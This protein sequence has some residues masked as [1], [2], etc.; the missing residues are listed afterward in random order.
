MNDGHQDR[1]IVRHADLI[2]KL[3]LAGLI[4]LWV[5]FPPQVSQPQARIETGTLT[6]R[7]AP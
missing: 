5:V 1:W 7:V 3:V 2:Y 4:V 6:A